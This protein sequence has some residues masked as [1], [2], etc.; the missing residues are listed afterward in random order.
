M[1][2]KKENLNPKEI[3]K[4]L[5]TAISELPEFVGWKDYFEGGAGQTIIELIAGSQAIKNHYNLMRVRESSLQYAR[6]DSSITELAINKGVFRPTAK[7]VK[8]LVSFT[9]QRSGIVNKGELIGSYMDMDVYSLESKNIILG[10]NELLITIGVIN[11]KEFE[12]QVDEDFIQIDFEYDQQF[13]GD[14]F[15]ELNVNGDEVIPSSVQMNLYNKD[16]KKS[17]LSLVYDYR[18][19]LVFG[20]GVVGKKVNYN[21]I[22]LYR[23][24]NFNKEITE[25]IDL[26]KIKFDDDSFFKDTEF[27]IKRKATKYLDKD[28]LKRIALRSSIDG[29]WVE[30]VDYQSGIMKEFGEYLNDVIA[31]DNYPQEDIY[32]LPIVGMDTEEVKS[33]IYEL[34]ENKR[35]NAVKV[36]KHWVDPNLPEN[37]VEININLTYY[38]NDTDEVIKEVIEDYKNEVKNKISLSSYFLVAADVAV[39][40]TKRLPNGKMYASLDENFQIGSLVYIKTLKIDYERA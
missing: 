28:K 26:D 24:L 31:V 39:E 5:Q 29:R 9:S 33:E 15:Q 27:E 23:T 17:A 14:F 16:I 34:I 2:F 7:C 11:E 10:R 12:V 19:R 38:G 20:D 40:L 3:V 36:E 35:G 37:Y 13:V 6:M 1:N 4:D 21:D 25:I 30:T 32:F 8:I 22:I 18:N